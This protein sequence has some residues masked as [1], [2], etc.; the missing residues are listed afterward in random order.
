GLLG[1]TPEI[2]LALALARRALDLILFLPGLL[3]WQI[4]EGRKLLATA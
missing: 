2:A 1:L 3:A 4:A